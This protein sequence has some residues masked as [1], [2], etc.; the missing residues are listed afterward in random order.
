M[1]ELVKDDRGNSV[2]GIAAAGNHATVFAATALGLLR[3]HD[4]GRSFVDA[5]AGLE[6]DG[7]VSVIAVALSPAFARDH[8]VF[9]G[10]TGGVLRS[11][12]GGESWRA[13][14]LRTPPPVISCLATSPAYEE[15][16]VLFA[17][18]IEDGVFRSG[19]RGVTWASWNFGLIDLGVLCLALSPAF[20]A[21]EMLLA[22]TETGIYRSAN[23]GRAW[24]AAGLPE[25]AGAIA[26]LAFSL[27]YATDRTVWAG[28]EE[29]G[30]W[31]SHDGARSWER[32]PE[33][34]AGVS[35]LASVGRGLV[36][37]AVDGLWRLADGVWRR[38]DD[39]DAE[40]VTCVAVAEGTALL[41]CPCGQILRLALQAG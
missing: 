39:C 18:T 16:G 11:R 37:A 36:V 7:P 17:G 21:D 29:S 3:S 27:N 8:T 34:A 9:A 2:F 41:G 31:V 32:V 38:L 25:E 33:R 5:F 13:A 28:G 26:A 23:G 19:D 1:A 20:G 6:L 22:G 15:D 24:R 10:V 4:G 30:L 35:A 12:D 14:A 40:D